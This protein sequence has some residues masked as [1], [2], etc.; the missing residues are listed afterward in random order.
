MKNY[1]AMYKEVFAT[2]KEL[3]E[4]L[5]YKYD[6][7]ES[8]GKNSYKV[9]N[10]DSLIGLQCFWSLTTSC[11]DPFIVSQAREVLINVNLKLAESFNL[12]CRMKRWQEFIVQCIDILKSSDQAHVKENV[13]GLIHSF[14]MNFDGK[15]YINGDL[16]SNTNTQVVVQLKND[17]GKK[18]IINLP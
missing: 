14:F 2:I 13:V 5:N 10:Y 16:P 18:K 17:E 1:A 3:F 11:R 12:E 15:R 4:Y 8:Y 6:N 7:I 9:K